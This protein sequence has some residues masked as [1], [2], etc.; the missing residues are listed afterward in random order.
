MGRLTLRSSARAAEFLIEFTTKGSTDKRA[1]EILDRI[2]EPSEWSTFAGWGVVAGV[3]H[4]EI[5]QRA[6]GHVGT[7]FRVENT[8][9]STHKESVEA[10]EPG[11]LLVMEIRDFSAPLRWFASHFTETW[12]FSETGVTTTFERSFRLHPSNAVGAVVLRVVSLFLRKAVERHNR[13]I[14]GP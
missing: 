7:V 5:V 3:A 11:R 13:V 12:S 10:F 8:D 9:G 2:F 1:G 4:A 6:P 14:I